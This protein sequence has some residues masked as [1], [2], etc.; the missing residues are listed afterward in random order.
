MLF[1]DD[2]VIFGKTVT[3]LQNSLN[4]LHEYC[5]KWG[6]EV[7]TTKTK[8]MV[9]RKRGNVRNDETWL[10]NNVEL[11]VVNDF[12]YLG[13]V[14][15][16]TDSFVLNQET[17]AGKGIKALN[18]LLNK[19]KEY[20]F[21]PSVLCQLFD[22]FV[23]AT[24]NYGAEIWGFGK[25]KEIERIHL[26]FCKS[27]LGVKSSTCN[28]AVYGELGRFPLYVN[29]YT[30]I[31]KFWCKT[32]RSENI[33]IKKLY[34]DM[35]NN[36]D[37]NWAKQVK[38]LLDSYGFSEVWNSPYSVNLNTFHLSFKNVVLDNFKQAWWQSI[39]NS[40]TL[41]TYKYIKNSFG[42][43]PYLDKCI[44]S[45]KLRKPMSRLRLSSHHLHIESGRYARQRLER[46]QRYC[47][48]CNTLD[49]EDEYHFVIKC[50]IYEN[51]RKEFIKPYYTRRPSMFKFVELMTSCNKTVIKNLCRFVSQ[52]FVLRNSL[53]VV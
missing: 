51:L 39:N 38:S 10:Y 4:L 17:L 15:N 28:M 12:N 8:V 43:E 2:M 42:F 5:L 25:A 19:T 53:I 36:L 34:E 26:K 50:P 41:C 52:A 21:K 23:G 46:N 44:L 9:F 33:I 32:L 11:K 29:R 35:L 27:I 37:K 48:L 30:R 47:A 22:A 6:L 1:A 49:I 31:V 16:Y 40:G 3:G 7:N 13:T 20:N 14:F 24:L 45:K 18:V